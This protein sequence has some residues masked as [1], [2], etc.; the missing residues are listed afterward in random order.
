[1]VA[2]S[3]LVNFWPFFRFSL[4]PTLFELASACIEKIAEKFKQNRWTSPFFRNLR[5]L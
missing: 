2:H 4:R 1:M 5:V 3:L